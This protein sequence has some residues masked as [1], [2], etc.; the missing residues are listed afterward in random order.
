MLRQWF[1]ILITVAG[2]AGF[3]SAAESGSTLPPSIEATRQEISAIVHQQLDAFK[4]RD[5]ERAYTFAAAGIREKFSLSDFTAMVQS[6]YP[7]LLQGRA[8]SD[9]AITD[10]GVRGTLELRVVTTDDALAH[11]RYFLQREDNSWRIVGV[12]PFEPPSTRA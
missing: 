2:A 11:F 10:D 9:L 5:W 4:V 8:A 7:Q 3:L 1:G 6:N 12:I